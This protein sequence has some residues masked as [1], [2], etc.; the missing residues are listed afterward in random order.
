MLLSS[1]PFKPMAFLKK[2]AQLFSMAYEAILDPLST[3]S[4]S[5]FIFPISY[6]FA[7][8]FQHQAQTT[9]EFSSFFS[10]LDLDTNYFLL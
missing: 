6:I 10:T 1:T 4:N 5:L 3:G 8:S 9:K 7:F 2:K